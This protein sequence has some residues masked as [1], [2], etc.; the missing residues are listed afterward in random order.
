YPWQ[1]VFDTTLVSD[2]SYTIKVIAYDTVNQTG[3]SGINV[4]V[5][6][7]DNPPTIRLIEP[8]NGI[9]VSGSIKIIAQA[10]DDKGITKV[11]FYVDDKLRYTKDVSP[12]EWL[13]DTDGEK[14]DEHIIKVK[15]YDTANQWSEVVVKLVVS[16]VTTFSRN[17]V[18]S[19]PNPAVGKKVSFRFFTPKTTEVKIRVYNIIGHL[20]TEFSV[21]SEAGKDNEVQWDISDVAPG[22][23]I[24]T[25]EA[26][27]H[28]IR[29][30]LSI[31]K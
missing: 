9:T 14:N 25:I 17:S 1:W 3:M 5:N 31:V 4:L 29:K 16:N 8:K 12:Y 18:F 30:K 10:S 24:Y 19:Y 13:W 11:E 26:Y 20:I 28:S 2:S 27:G 23:Y 21:M 22:I 6:N 7:I 15:A